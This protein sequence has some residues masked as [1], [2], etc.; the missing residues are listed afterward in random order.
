MPTP[1]DDRNLGLGRSVLAMRRMARLSQQQLGS[2][3]GL[4]GS[5]IGSI[6]RGTQPLT[7]EILREILRAMGY[8]MTI[9]FKRVAPPPQARQESLL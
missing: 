6:E 1:E 4:S 8:T 9:K 7:P 5:S 3:V 2:K